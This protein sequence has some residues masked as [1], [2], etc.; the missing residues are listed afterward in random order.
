M[1]PT[2]LWGCSD[3]FE[4][5]LALIAG[6]STDILVHIPEKWNRSLDHMS[7]THLST[8]DSEFTRIEEMIELVSRVKIETDDVWIL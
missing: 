4:K 8:D 5:L 3:E 2:I 6:P 7:P 1:Y